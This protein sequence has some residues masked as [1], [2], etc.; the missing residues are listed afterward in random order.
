METPPEVNISTPGRRTGALVIGLVMDIIGYAG[1]AFPGYGEWSDIVWA[2]LSAFLFYR[3]Y[4]SRF[5]LLG[6]SLHFF[7]EL[8]PFTDIIPFYCIAW[9]VQTYKPERRRRRK[10]LI[11]N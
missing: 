1:F 9:M 10:A 7:E 11:K 6:T 8:L 4:G 2:P 5:G 3:L